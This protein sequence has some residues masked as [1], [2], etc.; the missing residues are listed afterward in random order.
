MLLK[1]LLPIC[2]LTFAVTAWADDA[3]IEKATGDNAQTVADIV[4]KR[5]DLKDQV[6]QVRGKVVKYNPSIMGKNWVHLQDGTGDE[7][8]GTNDILV[9]TDETV[10][11]GDI[12]TATG[13]VRVDKSFGFGYDY[14][15]MMEEATLA[16]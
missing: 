4:T 5:A 10:A 2:L 14:E 3:P 12:V 16:P 8:E 15:V 1:K 9:T 7:V 11:V 13:T 6:V